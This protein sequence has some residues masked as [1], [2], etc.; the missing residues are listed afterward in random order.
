MDCY[1]PDGFNIEL[2]TRCPLHCPQCYCTLEGGKD[3]PLE[4][5]IARLEEASRLGVSHVELSGGETLCYPHLYE[6]VAAARTLGIAPSIAISGWHFDEIVFDKLIEAGIDMICVSLNGPRAEEN[7]K[8]RDGYEYAIRALEILREKKFGNTLINWVMHRDSVA[9]LP[10]MIELAEAYCV[11]GIL[12]ID[13]KPT[14]KGEWETYPTFEQMQYVARLVKKN[15][16][17]V[18]L[19]VQHCFSSLLALSCDN[20][21][22]GNS[23]RGLY[24]GCTAGLCSYCITVDGLYTPCR[25]LD[26]H[27]NCNSAE[28]YWMSS[29]V[30]QELRRLDE[31]QEEPCASCRLSNYCRPCLASNS[32]L[33]GRL[34]RGNR[35]CPLA[36]KI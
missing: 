25:H 12:I 7:A 13:P 1:T 15:R 23:N 32:K 11:S 30:L 6:V 28:E 22:W 17:P 16:S 14:S 35:G 21:L 3:I 31:K 36:E 20:R 10:Q 9:W 5:A 27:E 26:Y 19:T 8:S 4:T 24:K 29:P 2:T 18:E 33:E 34:Y